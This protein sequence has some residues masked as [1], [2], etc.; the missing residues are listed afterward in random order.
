MEERPH[1]YGD[2]IKG[3]QDADGK[4]AALISVARPRPKGPGT[5]ADGRSGGN[6]SNLYRHA[7]KHPIRWAYKLRGRRRGLKFHA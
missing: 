2:F 7:G 3:S 1:S 5:S 4:L 6:Y